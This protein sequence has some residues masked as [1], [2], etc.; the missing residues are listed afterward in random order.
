MV[1]KLA[2]PV[3]VNFSCF[4]PECLLELSGALVVPRKALLC[5]AVNCSQRSPLRL[6]SSS[7]SAGAPVD[8]VLRKITVKWHQVS[9]VLELVWSVSMP[10]RPSGAHA[11]RHNRAPRGAPDLAGQRPTLNSLPFIRKRGGTP[12][13]HKKR[14]GTPKENKSLNYT[15][16]T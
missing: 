16:F 11:D 13:C 4:Y 5:S 14:R 12:C 10:H 1:R 8:F 7:A 2:L 6:G 15:L 9:L 3:H